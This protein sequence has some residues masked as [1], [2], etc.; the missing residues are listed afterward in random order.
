MKRVLLFFLLFTIS[1]YAYSQQL[2]SGSYKDKELQ[3]VLSDIES[4][5]DIIFSYSKELIGSMK[6]TLNYKEV[7]IDELVKVISYETG[8]QLEQL[9]SQQIIITQNKQICGRIYDAE[10]K[11]PLTLATVISSTEQAVTTDSTG[12]FS[13]ESTSSTDVS[14]RVKYIGYG[15]QTISIPLGARCRD[16]YL[17]PSPESL[18]EVI[19]LGYV[20][21]GIDKYEDGSVSI[22]TDKLGILPGLVTPDIAQSIQLIPGITS[23]DES[24]TGIQIRG[25]APDQN[26]IF[27]DNIKLY[28]TG[29]FYGMFS[30]FNPYATQKAKIFKSGASPAYGDRVAGVID[31]STGNEIPKKAQGGFG[32]DGLSVDG[33]FKAPVSDKVAVYLFARRSYADVW[34]SPTYDG[35]ATKIFKNSGVVTNANNEVIEIIS[36]DEF[37]INTSS[38]SFYYHDINAKVLVKPSDTD[39]IAISGLLT[40]NRLDFSFE[41]GGEIRDDDLLTQNKGLSVHWRKQG[42]DLWRHDLKAYFSEYTSDYLN[43]E[44][45]DNMLE[46]SNTRNNEISDFG[47]DYNLTHYFP[48]GH[49]AAVGYQYTNAD[50]LINI[51]KSEPLEPDNLEDNF[52]SKEQKL[53]TSHALYA[54]YKHSFGNS[55]LL[56][57]G[58]RGVQYSSLG[59]F[60]GEPRLNLEYPLSQAVRLKASAERRYQPISQLVEFNQ[61]EL[62][63]ENNLWTLSDDEQFPIL[64]STQFSA[65]FL[66]DYNGWTIDTDSYFKKINGLTSYTNGF[67]NPII[68]LSEGTSDILGVD[69]LIKKKI[70]NYRI[71]AG[72]TYNDIVYQFDA[73]R[74]DAFPGNN[75]ITHN[76]RISNTYQLN[77]WQFSLG[78]SYRTGEPLTPIASYDSN[79]A[80]ATFGDVNSSRLE[81]FHR[82]DVSIIYD[83]NF[84]KEGKWRGRFGLSVLNLYDRKIPLSMIYRAEDEG[85]GGIEL[86]QVVQRHSLGI[87]PNAVFR[88]FF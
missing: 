78:W 4:K 47:I 52:E 30:A 24:A 25:G 6:I 1:K 79:T 66:V 82:L 87:T 49:I 88:V 58:I 57:I 40:R 34:K 61:T 32:I 77:N 28:N 26:L 13:F 76:F 5:T 60:Y 3:L 22:D 10:T 84:S 48:N 63:L 50:V 7:T 73:L 53:N 56:S 16:I 75:D 33:F 31:I 71:W 43:V 74:S 64:S 62:R 29:Y 59:Q 17:D 27:L 45:V 35:Y 14:L 46:E 44:I 8:L 18:D 69:I 83:F 85:E 20:T 70:E 11:E 15:D 23:L 86:K 19:I 12:Y 2:L 42:S 9:S 37:D 38:N 80:F 21:T 54:E 65:G 39:Q 55:G 68:E 41:N 51:A 36:D 67:S 81:D 72:Y